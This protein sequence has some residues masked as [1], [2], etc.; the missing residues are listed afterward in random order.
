[1]SRIDASGIRKIFDLVSSLKDP[2]DL[3]IGQPDFDIPEE[4]KEI[5]IRAIRDGFNAYTPTQGILPLR[6]AIAEKLK[7]KNKIDAHP[8]D[9]LVTCGVSGGL[10]LAFNV[11]L[12]DG[13]EAIVFDPYFVSYKHIL[14]MLGVKIKYVDT[15]PDFS[16][17]P[18]RLESE[19]TE[20]TKAIVIN[21]PGNPT[22][23]VYTKRE[24]Y[25][26][27]SIAERQGITV[28][29]DEVYESFDYSGEFFSIGSI[30]RN[31]LTLSGFSKS[32]AMTGWRIGYAHGPHEV[33]QEMAKLQQYTFVCAPS[34]AQ[35]AAKEAFDY[36]ICDKIEEYKAKR[37]LIYEGLKEHFDVV[38]PEG[39]FYVFPRLR[40][41]KISA[42]EFV[43]LAIRKNV[44]I[45]PGSVFSEKDTNF[46]ISFAAPDDV[47][48]K[49]IEALREVA[50]LVF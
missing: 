45:I 14:N 25:Q 39:A 35:I 1:M 49:G 33:I 9:I 17:D 48:K 32:Y 19:I 50:Y 31:T 5:G 44:L 43:E 41:G 42:T 22:G 2:I 47:L 4:I 34:F 38:K 12:N 36:D 18:S 16:I 30:Y 29:S 6:E 24:L 20:R 21:T 7:E 40:E 10:F 8:E 27:A 23:K 26:V 11:L 15:Y 46:R 3:S 28:I 37:D 13:D